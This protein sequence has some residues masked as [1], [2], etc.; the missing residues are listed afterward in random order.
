MDHGLYS[1]IPGIKSVEVESHVVEEKVPPEPTED[2]VVSVE[3]V[4]ESPQNK[5]GKRY[6]F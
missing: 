6:T 4:P 3:D 5:P 2:D 1:F